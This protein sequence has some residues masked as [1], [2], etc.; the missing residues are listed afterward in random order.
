M[1]VFGLSIFNTDCLCLSF[2]S[3]QSAPHPCLTK[4]TFHT[5]DVTPTSMLGNFV[6][7]RSTPEHGR[8][9]GSTDNSAIPSFHGVFGREERAAVTRHL[10]RLK[11]GSTPCTA[12]TTLSL[13]S[14]RKTLCRAGSCA[15]ISQRLR[16]SNVSRRPL[17]IT[18][19][20]PT[21]CF[22]MSMSPFGALDATKARSR[23]SILVHQSLRRLMI[24]SCAFQMVWQLLLLVEKERKVGTST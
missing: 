8:V 10:K 11:V 6:R 23:P 12:T 18:T 17:A 3:K 21:I 14:R 9:D 19:P 20:A 1:W 22:M 13:T 15:L 16:R 7:I 2:V 5:L 24:A 4:T